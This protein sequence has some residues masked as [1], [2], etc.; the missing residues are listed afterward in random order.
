MLLLC[1][2]IMFRRTQLQR[3]NEIFRQIANH[4]LRHD[5]PPLSDAINAITTK[6]DVQSLIAL[7]IVI[8]VYLAS[9]VAFLHRA[10]ASKRDF[11]E[12]SVRAL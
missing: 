5:F 6:P 10:G 7:P 3:P 11:I 4:E 8:D 1:T 2:A 9:I 12:V